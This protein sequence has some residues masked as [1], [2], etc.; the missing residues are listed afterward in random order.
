MRFQDS[1]TRRRA[2]LVLRRGVLASAI[3]VGA[4]GTLTL[5]VPCEALAQG[6]P[7]KPGFN[8]FS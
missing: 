8:I 1:R 6:T 3:A 4:F 7:V 2:A 5:G